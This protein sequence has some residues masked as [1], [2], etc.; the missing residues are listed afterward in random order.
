M[1]AFLI[2]GWMKGLCE[3][4]KWKLMN[5]FISEFNTDLGSNLKSDDF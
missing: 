2:D 5:M 4:M 1:D 3:P